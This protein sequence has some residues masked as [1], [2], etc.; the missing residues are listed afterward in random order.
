M[1]WWSCVDVS[2]INLLLQIHI[3]IEVQHNITMSQPM[4][5]RSPP[6]VPSTY[7]ER[8]EWREKKMLSDRQNVI[9]SPRGR[10]YALFYDR[11]RRPAASVKRLGFNYFSYLFNL[12]LCWQSNVA[13]LIRYWILYVTFIVFLLVLYE[14]HSRGKTKDMEQG[15]KTKSPSFH[16]FPSF[17]LIWLLLNR[18]NKF[19]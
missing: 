17:T 14:C 7:G 11:F 16:S 1:I 15:N 4:D 19:K 3:N 12:C 5:V 10:R 18:A 2:L 8:T 9:C 6:A 13:W